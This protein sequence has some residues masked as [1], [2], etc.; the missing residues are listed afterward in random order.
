MVVPI[1]NEG[2]ALGIGAL[3]RD[4]LTMKRLAD[5]CRVRDYSNASEAEKLNRIME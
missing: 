3:L 1:D 5:A 2:C 4:A